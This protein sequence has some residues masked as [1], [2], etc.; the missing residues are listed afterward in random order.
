MIDM[1]ARGARIFDF[2][3]SSPAMG[4]L[5]NASGRPAE[6]LYWECALLASDALPDAVEEPE[7][8]ARSTPGNTCP[9]GWRTAWARIWSGDS[10][11]QTVDQCTG[12]PVVGGFVEL[13]APH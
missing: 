11:T 2:G 8:S 10:V 3:R 5:I 4:R 1:I 12:A 13:L 7:V 6:Q 9:W